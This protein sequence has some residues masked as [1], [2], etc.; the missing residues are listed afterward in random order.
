M[1]NTI[2]EIIDAMIIAAL[3]I[4]FSYQTLFLFAP[5]VKK[6]RNNKRVQKKRSESGTCPQEDE[7]LGIEF[8]H[9]Y[10]VLIAARNEEAVIANLIGSIKAQTYDEHLVDIFVVADNCTDQTATIARDA[11]ATVYERFSKV[12]VGKGYALKYLLD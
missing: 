4:C 1:L 3:I 5:Y 12:Q 10:G 2:T 6:W 7:K 11:G 9:R 8:R